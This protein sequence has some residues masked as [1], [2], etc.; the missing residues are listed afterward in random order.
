LSFERRHA[1]PGDGAER[2]SRRPRRHSNVPQKAS[3]SAPRP[4]TRGD[5]DTG[6][7]QHAVAEIDLSV[8]PADPAVLHN[9]STQLEARARLGGG[10]YINSLLESW[11][12]QQL[13]MLPDRQGLSNS[14]TRQ[15]KELRDVETQMGTFLVLVLDSEDARRAARR[16]EGRDAQF[17]V[18]AVQDVRVLYPP[19]FSFL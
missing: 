13:L 8:Q 7:V 16:L 17:F 9:P 19:H 3:H 10:H 18:D 12:Q 4:P 11:E 15:R 14:S 6:D 2:R 1:V 5:L